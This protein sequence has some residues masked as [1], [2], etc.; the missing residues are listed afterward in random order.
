MKI[1]AAIGGR[2]VTQGSLNRSRSGHT[3]HKN[4]PQLT[5][6][7]RQIAASVL[8]TLSREQKDLLPITEPVSLTV[9]FTVGKPASNKDEHAISQRT[10]DL[11]KYIRA[12]GDALTQGGIIKDDSLIVDIWGRKRYLGHEQ[13]LEVEGLWLVL[14]TVGHSDDEA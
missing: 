4:G 8:A 3:Y 2:P 9:H 5:L 10:G 11:D 6:W 1:E 13:A 7:R 12:V 14:V